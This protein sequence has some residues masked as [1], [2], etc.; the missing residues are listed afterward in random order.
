MRQEKGLQSG[1]SRTLVI[2]VFLLLLVAI[3]GLLYLMRG[4][5]SKSMKN[6]EQSKQAVTP[7]KN[8]P[9]E[10]N[11]SGVISSGYDLECELKV[12]VKAGQQNPFSTGKLWATKGKAR[13]VMT[14]TTN[15]MAIEANAIYNEKTM[16][17]W[18]V[19]NGAKSGFKVNLAEAIKEDGKVT[20][21]QKDQAEQYSQNMVSGCHP[22]SVD[23]SK[24]TLPTGIQFKEQS[25][26]SVPSVSIPAMMNR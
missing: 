11:I 18:T 2:V 26:P 15:N 14:G 22:W 17:I 19:I 25:L 3:A 10:G 5:T 1:F 20:Q 13:S 21:Q 8:N 6:S 7:K 16:Y 4:G 12:P 23:Q 24:F 9:N